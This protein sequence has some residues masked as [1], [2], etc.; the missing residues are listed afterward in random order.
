MDIDTKWIEE[1]ENE[2]KLYNFLYEEP[3]KNIKFT[4]LYI[5]QLSMIES[6][7]QDNLEL[8]ESNIISKEQLI[9]LIKKYQINETKKKYNLKSILLYTFPF[10]NSEIGKFIKSKDID[11]N[12]KAINYINDIKITPTILFFHSINNLYLIFHEKIE[13]KKIQ[14]KKII[15]SKA[16]QYVKNKTKK[17]KNFV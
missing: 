10:E 6:I 2:D 3:I 12:L 5:N 7:I 17:N 16:N 14:T 15:L 4:I 8:D 11:D 13:T 1:Y 9:K